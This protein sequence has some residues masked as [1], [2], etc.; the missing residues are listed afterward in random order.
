MHR[1]YPG[2]I[3]SAQL[4]SGESYSIQVLLRKTKAVSYAV[5]DP[6]PGELMKFSVAQTKDYDKAKALFEDIKRGVSR[7]LGD[8]DLGLLE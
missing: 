1:V 3:M 7:T 6:L 4:E 8:I 2:D 5:Q